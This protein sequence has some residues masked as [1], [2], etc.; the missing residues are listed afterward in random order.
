MASF[1][2]II[3]KQRIYS[4]DVFDTCLTRIFAQPTDLF[5]E[6]ERRVLTFGKIKEKISSKTSLALCRIR[7]EKKARKNKNREDICFADIYQYMGS[8]EL[9][10]DDLSFL[11]KSE[12]ELEEESLVPIPE[13]L[14]KIEE[15]RKKNNAPILFISNMY[16]PCAF[17]QRQLLRHGI[18]KPDD[19]VYVSGDIGLSK[20]TGSLFKY[21]LKKHNLQPEQL[22]HTGDNARSDI[23]AAQQLGV[24]TVHYTGACLTNRERIIASQKQ[25]DKITN[26]FIAGASRLC[27]TRLSPKPEFD[28]FDIGLIASVAAPM[29]I[30]FT[31]WVLR[32][33]YQDGIERLYF[34]SR[35]GQLFYKIAQILSD[36]MPVPECRYLYSSRLA[37]IGAS[38]NKTKLE[39]EGIKAI[40]IGN[41]AKSPAQI[42]ERLGI[43]RNELFSD[44]LSSI[45]VSFN[46]IDTKL[47]HPEAESFCIRLS[48]H[49]D[50]KQLILNRAAD[51]RETTLGYLR[52]EGLLNEDCRWAIV[53]IGWRLNSQKALYDLLKSI[54]YSKL[55]IGYYF[56]LS[57]DRHPERV[58]GPYKAFTSNFSGN[59]EMTADWAGRQSSVVLLENVFLLATHP[60][61]NKYTKR[62]GKIVPVYSQSSIHSKQKL[63]TDIL[64]RVVLDFADFFSNNEELLNNVEKVRESTLLSWRKFIN[65]PLPKEVCDLQ[66]LPVNIEFSHDPTHTRKLAAP[67]TARTLSQIVRHHFSH[68][69]HYE[70]SNHIW[71]EGSAVLSAPLIRSS[72]FLMQRLR[73]YLTRERRKVD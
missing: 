17:I 53:D 29:L 56:G 28:G 49:Q 62:N 5:F 21:V 38:I 44:L 3:Q 67:L 7:A 27:R 54:G 6:W 37:W 42:F 72:F 45:G 10:D 55:P 24:H 31:A 20:H 15:I 46:N 26:S 66:W 39:T 30:A 50:L 65:R 36:S 35:D 43:Q 18:A 73:R 61:L 33:A 34:L 68:T 4:F 16:L 14:Q 32:S 9:S 47:T 25:S 69:Q 71:L 58:T 63:L 1:P 19:P 2:L 11:M 22:V 52:Q 23:K 70:N 40:C 41:T 13:I 12:M 51:R 59:S 48:T 60:P 64:H 57:T 8:L